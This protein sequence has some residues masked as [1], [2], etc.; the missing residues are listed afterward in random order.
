MFGPVL[1]EVFRALPRCPIRNHLL[2]LNS[3]GR[4]DPIP[5]N[6]YTWGFTILR[7]VYTPE[8]D[9][10]F[11][12]TL[13][14]LHRWVVYLL[15]LEAYDPHDR[16][17]ATPMRTEPFEEFVSRLRNDIIED[18]EQLDGASWDKIHAYFENHL[19]ARGIDSK[20]K[21][22][23]FPTNPRYNSCIAIDASALAALQTMPEIPNFAFPPTKEEWMWA[24]LKATEKAWV[25]VYDLKP[26]YLLA[27][28]G[29]PL[30]LPYKGW[31]RVKVFSLF[32]YWCSRKGL[33][34][35]KTVICAEDP[36]EPGV[37]V[38]SGL[39]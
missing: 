25:W 17:L 37:I 4:H 3:L 10:L 7:T 33:D 15:R 27:T 9:T 38:W 21:F 11:A 28:Q 31:T 19:D 2:D 18:K 36:K 32:E 30:H 34:G 20:T 8:S 23:R 14:A 22:D 12:S 16:S 35:E 29:K 24:V 26:R 1:V 5:A 13:E 6:A 39:V